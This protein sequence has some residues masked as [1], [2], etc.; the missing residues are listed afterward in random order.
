MSVWSCF[1]N[2]IS[3]VAIKEFKVKTMLADLTWLPLEV[4]LTQIIVWDFRIILKLLA[5]CNSTR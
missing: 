5:I 1:S 4:S 3:H 2:S